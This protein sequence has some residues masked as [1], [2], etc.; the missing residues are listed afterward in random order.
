MTPQ[1]KFE[2]DF[3]D[4]CTLWNDFALQYDRLVQQYQT[5]PLSDSD[6]VALVTT[7]RHMS[8]IADNINML[9][10]ALD[11]RSWFRTIGAVSSVDGKKPD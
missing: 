5:Q 10:Y 7:G 1:D 6:R 2:R 9:K 8:N 4:M 11:G 3:H